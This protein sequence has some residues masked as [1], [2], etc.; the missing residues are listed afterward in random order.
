VGLFDRPAG[1]DCLEALRKKPAVPGLEPWQWASGEARS[2]AIF[3][4]R[5]AGLLLREDE[6]AA[7]S[8]DAHPLAREWYGQNFRREN[9]AGFKAAHSRLYDHLRRTTRE[10]DPPK[11]IAALEPLFQAVVHGCK[12]ERHEETLKNVYVNRLCRRQ[13]DGSVA[14]HAHNTLGA[15]GPRL[16][17]L[18]WFFDRPFDT[19]HGGLNAE[20]KK[21]VLGNAGS[22]LG[23]LGRL[24]EA[25]DAQRA[26]L[27]MLTLAKDWH[28]AAIIAGNFAAVDLALGEITA[29]IRDAGLGVDFA[30]RLEWISPIEVHTII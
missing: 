1:A 26:V 29:A 30:N 5:E 2:D 9:E 8:I 10:G 13:T 6:Q 12:A 23:V 11:D 16:A 25:R 19:P 24:S 27:E 4:L 18:A 3:E 17:A 22:F 21:W 14:F 7:R 20:C 28:N 15:F